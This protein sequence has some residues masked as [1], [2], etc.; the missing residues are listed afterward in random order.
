M[1]FTSNACPEVSKNSILLRASN[2][3]DNIENP[4]ESGELSRKGQKKGFSIPNSRKFEEIL[5]K[6]Q[7]REDVYL[8]YM[9]KLKQKQNRY[10]QVFS[11]STGQTRCYYLDRKTQKLIYLEKHRIVPGHKGGQYQTQNTLLL[12]FYEHI[13]AH[14]LRH[15]QYGE[16]A[17]F[18]AY[19]MMLSNSLE[20]RRQIASEAGKLGGT[21]QQNKLR[22]QK[23]GWFNSQGQSERGKK[24]AETARKRGVG[25]FDPANLALANKVGR[26]LYAND[27]EFRAKRNANLKLGTINKNGIVV[28]YYNEKN[29]L[30]TSQRLKSPYV[31]YSVRSGIEYTEE[32]THMSEDLFWYHLYY[33]P[34]P[35]HNYSCIL[36]ENSKD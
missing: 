11:E 9:E 7:E 23:G 18:K 19:T 14:Y 24:G 25:A 12:T 31:S 26:E 16:L 29:E 27:P 35:S 5:K 1:K 21:K 17:D 8:T 2:K 3:R 20:I 32:R 34:K 33:A 4:R 28:N 36:E 15:R 6:R 30:Q 13:M 22:E 10:E